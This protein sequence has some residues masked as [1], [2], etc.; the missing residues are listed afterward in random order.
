MLHGFPVGR[1]SGRLVRGPDDV[2]RLRLSVERRV[3]F[4]WLLLLST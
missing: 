2:R 1:S 4:G 3:G